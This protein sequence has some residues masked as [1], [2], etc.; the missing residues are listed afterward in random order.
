LFWRKSDM[1]VA[2]S[3]R[4]EL[5][6]R[7]YFDAVVRISQSSVRIKQG[8]FEAVEL[9][10][11]DVPHMEILGSEIIVPREAMGLGDVKFM[12]A[13]G[14]FLGWQAVL[15]SLMVSSLI[16]SAVG[17]TLILM[18]RREWS[19]KIPYG[20]YIAL[21]AAIWMFVGKKLVAGLFQ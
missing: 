12:A 18:K 2:R 16:G 21:A 17:V 9:N 19:S 10:P 6:D 4:V 15:F 11:E 20:P 1:I 8:K 3:K 7:S 14:A 13:I 5:I